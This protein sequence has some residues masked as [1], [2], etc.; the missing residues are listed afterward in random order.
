MF[1]LS[2]FCNLIVEFLEMLSPGPYEVSSSL[3]TLNFMTKGLFVG[4]KADMSL[5]APSSDLSKLIDYLQSSFFS[6][7]FN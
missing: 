1:D 3:F 5:N 6:S 4:Y 7:L 2:M